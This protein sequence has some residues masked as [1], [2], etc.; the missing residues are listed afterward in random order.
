MTEPNDDEARRALL[1]FYRDSGV[2]TAE[3]SEPGGLMAW[4]AEA[5]RPLT[6]PPAPREEQAPRPAP[7]GRA[8]GAMTAD[9]ALA[10]AERAAAAAKDLPSL[11]KAIAAFDGCPL[12]EAARGPVVYD[13][14]LG[15]DVLVIGEA[16]GREEDRLGKPFVGRSG[17]L[18]DRM[19]AAIDLSRSPTEGQMAVCIT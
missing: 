5:T 18:L 15:A 14:V 13:G 16:P 10:G 7:R 2:E 9:E 8:K 17:Q 12:K 11:V 6:P 4:K 1:A 3:V 19:L